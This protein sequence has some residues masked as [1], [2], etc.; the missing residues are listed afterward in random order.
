[1]GEARDL[2]HPTAMEMG[3]PDLHVSAPKRVEAASKVRALRHKAAVAAPSL[4]SIAS[5]PCAARA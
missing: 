4:D 2:A 3:V 1:M 5:F